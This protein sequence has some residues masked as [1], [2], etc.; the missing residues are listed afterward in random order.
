MTQPLKRLF[1]VVP[2]VA[3]AAFV[4]GGQLADTAPEVRIDRE[5]IDGRIDEA[6]DVVQGIVHRGASELAEATERPEPA[7][8]AREPAHAKRF[9]SPEAARPDSSALPRPATTLPGRPLG[10][11]EV[12]DFVVMQDDAREA[13]SD[14]ESVGKPSG[15]LPPR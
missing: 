4:A 9:V 1:L 8:R 6:R 12:P 3:I 11:V 15:R 13:R 5:V 14:D 10:G 7:G 2:V